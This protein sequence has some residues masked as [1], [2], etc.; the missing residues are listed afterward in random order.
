[1]QEAP[2]E[3]MELLATDGEEVAE[4][5]LRVAGVVLWLLNET[6]AGGVIASIVAGL[7][8]GLHVVAGAGWV[9]RMAT[10]H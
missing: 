3:L 1:L 2:E 5:A 9:M 10:S 6:Q 4:V 8:W 7:G